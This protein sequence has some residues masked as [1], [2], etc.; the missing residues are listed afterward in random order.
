K[1]RHLPLRQGEQLLSRELD[2]ARDAGRARQGAHDGGAERGLAAPRLAGD[3][4]DFAG[5]ERQL[6]VSDGARRPSGRTEREVQ[7]SNC[8]EGLAVGHGVAAYNWP[9]GSKP[10]F[11]QSPSALK[12]I[13]ASTMASPGQTVSHQA[14]LM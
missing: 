10:A 9:R 8:E 12:L 7:A 4:E 13:T 5:R 14:T 6:R 1:A 3:S 11:S 2:P